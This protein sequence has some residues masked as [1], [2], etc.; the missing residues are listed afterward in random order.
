[1]IL[2]C[3]HNVIILSGYFRGIGHIGVRNGDFKIM[4]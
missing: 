2:I 1:M 3:V 4:N